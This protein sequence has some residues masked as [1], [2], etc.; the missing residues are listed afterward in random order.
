MDLEVQVVAVVVEVL[1]C[2]AV[3]ETYHDLQVVYLAGDLVLS[4]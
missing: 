3:L 4:P 2:A 1:P